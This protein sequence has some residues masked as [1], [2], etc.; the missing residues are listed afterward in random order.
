MERQIRI[1]YVNTF[2]LLQSIW[3]RVIKRTESASKSIFWCNITTPTQNKYSHLL[4]TNPIIYQFKSIYYEWIVFAYIDTNN[5]KN[6]CKYPW[7]KD[8]HWPEH[9]EWTIHIYILLHCIQHLILAFYTP[10]TKTT[11]IKLCLYV[12]P[13]ICL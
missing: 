4:R 6:L 3:Y 1:F 13:F 9:R 5:K 10:N 7:V 2:K 11:N 8:F 12:H